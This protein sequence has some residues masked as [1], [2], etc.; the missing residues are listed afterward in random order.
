MTKKS[1]GIDSVDFASPEFHGGIIFDRVSGRKPQVGYERVMAREGSKM[2]HPLPG[3]G[4]YRV[5]PVRINYGVY[6]YRITR[7]RDDE[8]FRKI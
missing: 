5:L 8:P 2:D 1:K 6:N 7:R 3:A 4:I